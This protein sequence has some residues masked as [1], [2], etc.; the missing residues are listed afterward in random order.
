M[1]VTARIATA[2]TQVRSSEN[3][4]GISQARPRVDEVHEG[5]LDLLRL[6]A[7]SEGMVGVRG[8]RSASVHNRRVPF[9]PLR[10]LV[11]FAGLAGRTIP[12]KA[13]M[14]H[15]GERPRSCHVGMVCGWKVLGRA[16]SQRRRFCRLMV[17]NEWDFASSGP[18]GQHECGSRRSRGQLRFAI[19]K[20]FRVHFPLIPI[21]SEPGNGALKVE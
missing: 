1:S 12:E 2:G 14:G 11:P 21:E 4:K 8:G 9:V 19:R 16:F 15:D 18:K 13:T 5:P 7:M 10:S 6:S 17:E 20:R 3:G